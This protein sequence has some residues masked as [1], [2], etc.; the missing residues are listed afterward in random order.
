ML[1]KSQEQLR[2][3]A[4]MHVKEDS[5]IIDPSIASPTILLT[6]LLTSQSTNK[7]K[8]S[9][10]SK[11]KGTRGPV[12]TAYFPVNNDQTLLHSFHSRA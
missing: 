10:K 7:K 1:S 2:E 6:N 5:F 4:H 9:P 12:T 11:P 3:I 8:N